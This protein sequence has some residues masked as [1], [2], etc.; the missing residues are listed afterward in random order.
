MIRRALII[1]CNNTQSG[2]L[3]GP[4]KDNE[5]YRRFLTSLLGGEW[6]DAEIKSLP[7]P[8]ALRVEQMRQTHLMDADYTFIIFTGHG[9]INT[10]DN[11]LQ[12]IELSDKWVS[13]RKLKTNAPRQTI[14]FD[15]CRGLDAFDSDEIVKSVNEDLHLFSAGSPTRRLFDKAVLD[16]DIGVSVL[17]AAGINESAKDSSDGA[18]YLLSLL[19][20][21]EEWAKE[22]SE[23]NSLTVKGVHVRAVKY[24]DDH[25]FTLQNPTMDAEKRNRYFPFAVKIRPTLI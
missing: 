11:N 7:N 9:F 8:N 14:I 21:A 2:P 1:Y 24:M 23:Y 13:I 6:T 4:A 10:D 19:R 3:P 17:Y 18:M 25:F 15:A 22:E 20:A 12:Y 5:N 16:A